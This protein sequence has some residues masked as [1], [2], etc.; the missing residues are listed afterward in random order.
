[1]VPVGVTWPPRAVISLLHAD[2][3][4]T[5]RSTQLASLTMVR[6][7]RVHHLTPRA[8]ATLELRI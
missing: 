7:R 2:V 6:R 1:M 5:P 8:H 3:V 4:L